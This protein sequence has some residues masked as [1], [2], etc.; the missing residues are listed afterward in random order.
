MPEQLAARLSSESGDFRALIDIAPA[1]VW[2]ATED[3]AC[4]FLSKSWVSF[5]GQDAADGLGSGWLQAIHPND[6]A[7]V[8]SAFVSARADKSSYQTEYRVRTAAG[9][10]RWVLDSASPII[11]ADGLV[12]GYIG[13]I[14]DNEDRKVAE[15]E[16]ERSERRL[17]VALTASGIG[18]WEWDVIGNHFTLSPRALAIFGFEHGSVS[19]ERLQDCILAED[20]PEVQRLS[21]LALD[22][23]VRAHA[24]Y[25]Y[26]IRRETDQQVRWVEAHGEALFESHNGALRPH[27]YIGTFLDI[28]EHV[29]QEQRAREDATRLELALQA[30]DLAVWELDIANDRVSPSPALNKLYGFAE[31]ATPTADEFRS[32]YAPGEQ[33]RLEQLGREALARGEDRIRAEVKHILPEGTVRWLLIQA[34]SAA[35]LPGGGPRAI[36]VVMDI[37]DRKLHE[38]SLAV[39]AREMEHR[40]KNSLT[41]VQSLVQ[42]SFRPDRPYV[43]AKAIFDQR[44]RAYVD[45][46]ELIS[47]RENQDIEIASLLTR[48][49]N[50][51]R[52]SEADQF[53]LEGQN[54][55]VQSR[56]AFVLGLALHE[57]ATNSVKYGALSVPEGRVKVSWSTSDTEFRLDWIEM[58]GPH[59]TPPTRK[60]FGTRLLSGALL[61][62]VKGT[63]NLAYDPSGVRFQLLISQPR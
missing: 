49:L 48:A 40:V 18:T 54:S 15:L 23:A 51:F 27:T 55:S 34:Q 12:Q 53:L 57:L 22:P 30:A 16:R 10:Y 14:V 41:L 9:G 31:D 11:N 6:R 24:P 21:K 50:P 20:L 39:A 44:L 36:G 26:R 4:T 46:T 3:G 63:A 7:A 52:Q 58:G 61:T 38:E 60:G 32:R 35:P 17:Q 19:Y 37:T 56:I 62:N 42:Q 28:T 59:V 45:V 2:V 13:S 25:R 1:M 29:K 43:E 47:G 8:Q 5:T 33:E